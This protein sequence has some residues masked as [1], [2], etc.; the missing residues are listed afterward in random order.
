MWTGYFKKFLELVFGRLVLPLEIAF[1][2]RYE[3]LTGVVGFLPTIAIAN[4]YSEMMWSVLLPLLS[5]LSALSSA[6]DSGLS[7]RSPA[8]ADG[9]FHVT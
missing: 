1:D 7:G 5:T 3:L 2:S 6:F 8:A 4:H 9:R